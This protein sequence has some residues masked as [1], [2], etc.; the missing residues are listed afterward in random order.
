MYKC[1][2][3]KPSAHSYY[4]FCSNI[5]Y[6]CN[7]VITNTTRDKLVQIQV[8]LLLLWPILLISTPAQATNQDTIQITQNDAWVDFPQ[9]LDFHLVATA[10]API[11]SV[12]IEYGVDAIVCGDVTTVAAP[13]L[14][15]DTALDVTWR[16]D[17][18]SGQIIP[19]G[20]K[21]WWRWQLTTSDG[22]ETSTPTQTITFDDDWYVWESL[23][24]RNRTVHWYRG[25]PALAREMLA[26]GHRALDQLAADTGLRLQDPIAIYLYE[27]PFDLRISIPGAPTWI[28]GIAFPEYNTVLAVANETY[29]DYGRL[30]VRHELGHLVIQRLTF[31]CLTDL[32]VWLSEGLAMAAE[33]QGDPDA[34][35][36]LAEAIDADRI[37][38]IRQI[39][40]TFSVHAD[41]AHLSYA[42]SYSLV[43]F[44]IDT[45]GQEKMLAL[46]TAF[47]E[48]AT[49]DDALTTA[50]GFDTHGLESAWRVS[51]GASP[52]TPAEGDANT[53]T[54]VPTLALSTLPSATPTPA[55]PPTLALATEMPTAL[56][57]RPTATITATDVKQDEP[58]AN[59][60][61]W[62]GGTLLVI[63][64]ISFTFWRLRTR[65]PE[66]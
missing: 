36:T 39:E 49:P 48:G 42:E 52:I 46:L 62:A 31:N 18:A 45:Y 16:W 12:T 55:A 64:A 60:L 34:A 19:P 61:A 53:P 35:D 41:R 38:T 57:T 5:C 40:S 10:T 21:I 32:P 54:P 9:A 2:P 14:E 29:T 4:C 20:G 65:M 63:L 43:R 11:E 23:Q 7:I 28:G 22:T 26:A 27:E 15:P 13:D 6:H 25:Q 3:S 47:R 58:A 17:I 44:L 51:I 56:P 50:Y 37:L 1:T 66:N 33:G 8:L 59:W 24:E 30:T